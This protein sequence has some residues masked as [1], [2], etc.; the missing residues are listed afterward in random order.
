MSWLNEH[1]VLENE[2]VRLEPLEEK[3]FE[4]LNEIAQQ[5]ELWAFTSVKV[6]SREDFRKYFDEALSE[7]AIK[8]CYPFAIFDKHHNRFG[9]CTRFGN[10]SLPH[11]KAEIG[12]TWY[13]PSL[14]RTGLNR[15]CKFL[16]LSFAF[17]KLKLNRVELKTS[18]LNLK[19]QKA[20]EQ[21]GAVKEGIL[22]NHMINDDGVI[23]HSHF[24]SFIIEDW[25]QVKATV[26]AA[27][28]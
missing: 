23:R 24:Y 16:L 1:I 9:G 27:Y 26:F 18:H 8:Q 28:R 21:I 22:R 12:W 3:H 4:V 25:P 15:N 14:Q 17:E 10:I 7:K 5:R 19:S 11:K 13:D 6:N 2:R 20:M